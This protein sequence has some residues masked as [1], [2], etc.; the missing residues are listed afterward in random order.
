MDFAHKRAESLRSF[1]NLCDRV[2][3][4]LEPFQIKIA[5]A[6]LGPEREK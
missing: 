5:S 1:R 3:F 2:G 4:R 6:L